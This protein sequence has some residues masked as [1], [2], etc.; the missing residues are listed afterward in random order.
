M[1]GYTVKELIDT[2]KTYP[3]DWKV[4]IGYDRGDFYDSV[5]TEEVTEI[6]G[7]RIEKSDVFRGYQLAE[8][9]LENDT[10]VILGRF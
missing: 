1:T 7:G 8:E 10:H 3:D 6:F 9:S 4:C 2:L 5:Q